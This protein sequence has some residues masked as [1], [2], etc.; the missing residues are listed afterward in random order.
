MLGGCACFLNS[1]HFAGKFLNEARIVTRLFQSGATNLT[2][3]K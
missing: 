2:L 3:G 1:T